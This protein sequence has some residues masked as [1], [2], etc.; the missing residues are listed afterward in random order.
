MD[1]SDFGI[2]TTAF[3]ILN[4]ASVPATL[5]YDS[6]AIR[7]VAIARSN[8]SALRTLR[9]RLVPGLLGANVAVSAVLGILA[10][11]EGLFGHAHLAICVAIL[12]LV[13]PAF[14][15]V[16]VGEGWLRGSGSVLRAQISSGLIVPG[17]FIVLAVLGSVAG[18]KGH[19]GPVTALVFR[20]VATGAGTGLV[21]LMVSRSLRN[22]GTTPLSEP[23][24]TARQLERIG[25]IVCGGSALTML[26]MQI[27]VIAVS[28][29][30]GA[31]D[32]GVYGAASRIA[33][34]LNVAVVSANFVLSPRIS[35]LFSER[36]LEEVATDVSSAAGWMTLTMAIACVGVF[37]GGGWIL[38]LFGS[39]FS[40]G[41][42]PLRILLVGQFVNGVTGPAGAVLVMTGHQLKALHALIGTV[43]VD[44][45]AL[46][47]LIPILGITGAALASAA[48]NILVNV[49][50]V[51]QA[52]RAVGV[53][54]LPFMGRRR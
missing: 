20:L 46:V 54:T 50:M 33:L 44:V 23:I 52:R 40:R 34:A 24:P 9:V 28:Y 17:L 3:A 27:D 25:L 37:L 8:G 38:H 42:L 35:R 51:V 16:R 47:I 22:T 36:R 7:F 13:V 48:A 30:R 39:D 32:A 14:A 11:S 29:L 10:A 31:A 18:A 43:V 1:L 15:I 4:V 45:V 2:V 12:I 53:W 21:A 49:V 6:A 26:L 5:G 19:I 41:L